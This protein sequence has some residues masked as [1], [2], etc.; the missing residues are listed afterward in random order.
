MTALILRNIRATRLLR[1]GLRDLAGIGIAVAIASGCARAQ[2]PPPTVPAQDSDLPPAGYGTLRQEQVSLGLR[3]D[4]LQIQVVPLDERV[5]RLLAPDT[6]NSLHRLIES[7]S[8][9]IED[10]ARRYGISTPTMFLV[11]FFG[12]QQEARFNPEDLTITSQNRLFRSLHILPLSPIWSGHQLSQ[13]ETATAV[14][15]YD[16]G[17]SIFDPMTVEYVVIRNNNWEQ[18]LRVLDRERSSVLAR[19]AADRR[20]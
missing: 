1:H 3:T 12:L 4:R 15:L 9:E 20:P 11:T 19:A 17:V 5:I 6:Y 10:A 13:R 8:A 14:Y 16:E 7:K 2:E 18:I